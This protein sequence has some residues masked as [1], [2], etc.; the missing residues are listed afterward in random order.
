MPQLTTRADAGP[1]SLRLYGEDAATWTNSTAHAGL[2]LAWARS[3]ALS[4]RLGRAEVLVP[5]GA[6]VVVPEGVDH[7]TLMSA[8]G[9]AQS[10]H[11]APKLIAQLSAELGPR[12]VMKGLQPGVVHTGEVMHR[13][14]GWATC[15]VPDATA[16]AAD[17]FVV[18]ILRRRLQ[19]EQLAEVR[20]VRIARALELVW[21]QSTGAPRVED[22]CE[23]AGMSRFHFSRQFKARTGQSPCQFLLEV[24]L[25]HAADL[26]RTKDVSVTEA[27]TTAG[28]TDLSRFAQSFKKRFGTSP[29]DFKGSETAGAH[30]K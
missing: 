21:T 3:G 12:V 16:L 28:F 19:N 7:R 22:L 6:V 17:G 5:P 15:G 18:E 2:E 25:A 30:A 11:L 10:L 1:M 8:G 26:L 29:K 27:A 20:D 9:V 23:A 13:A 4:Y 24:R 14:L